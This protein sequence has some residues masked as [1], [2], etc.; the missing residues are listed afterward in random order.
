MRVNY[1]YYTVKTLARYAGFDDDTAQF[2]AYFSQYVDEF[3]M[4]QPIVVEGRPP[5]F[6]VNNKLAHKLDKDYWVFFPC[7]TGVHISHSTSHNYQLHSLMPFHFITPSPFYELPENPDRSVYRCVAANENDDLL[8]NRLLRMVVGAAD[9]HDRASLMA[10]GMM[11]HTFA[12]T[13]SHCG[14][15]GFHGW[16]NQAY[17]S[18]L[19]YK[20][21]YKQNSFFLNRVREFMKEKLIGQRHQSN[22]VN[23]L[24]HLVYSTLP[25][26]GH[27]NV[28]MVP[29][30][31][32]SEIIIYAKQTS[33]S[34]MKALIK[35]DNSEHFADCSR[36][37]INMLCE[38]NGKIPPDNDKW[39]LFQK[40]LSRAQTVSDQGK[41]TINKRLW[42]RVFPDINYHYDKG[43]FIDLKLEPLDCR[44]HIVLKL[45]EELTREL[46]INEKDLSDI[47]SIKGDQARAALP[48]I[49]RD[50]SELFYLYNEIAYRHVFYTT[51]EYVSD[52]DF[53]LISQYR[54][55]VSHIFKLR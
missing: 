28:G 7:A 48:M 14:F 40:K 29:D 26:I 49:A 5:D 45:T 12:D 42:S 24:L 31:C 36:R 17:A 54:E 47:Y 13:Y 37:I 30:C 15:S 9:V 34:K 21:P 19:I 52:G 18:S 32:E 53:T 33:E 6:F 23:L 41:H 22:S 3:I 39:E 16:E 2:I 46:D 20:C 4:R 8:I 25:S 11:L 27:A 43:E 1:H 44:N 55:F 50:V 38:I 35:R 51:G 10:L